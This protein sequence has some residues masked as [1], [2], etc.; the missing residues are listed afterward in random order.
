MKVF[1]TGAT[2]VL[3]RRVVPLLTAAG[4]TVTAVGRTPEKR[5][6]LERAGATAADVY[7][8]DAAA[9]RAAVA[10]HDA[11]VNLATRIPPSSRAAFPGAWKENDRIRR[12]V[13]AHLADAILAAGGGRLVQESFAPMYADGAAAW[14]D[15]SAPLNPAPHTRSTLDAERAAA[16]VTDGGGT[17]VALRFS[18]FYGPDGAFAED[19]IKAVRRGLAP[20]FGAADR[21]F[22]SIH[23]DD[24]ASAVVAALDLPAGVYNVTDDEPLTRRQ[25][26]DALADALGVAP[27]RFLPAWLAR[28]MGSVGEL[29][30]RSQRMSNAKLRAASPWAPRYPSARE[31]WRAA[32]AD[33]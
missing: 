32:V 2:G 14:L 30:T 22:S 19:F 17:G 6:A 5:A 3:G 15:E 12:E 8:F 25:F 9:V 1:V 10:G 23:H 4:H 29:L 16:R 31:G 11:V 20:S 13:S 28:V 33:S 7:L 26:F 27:P 21:Y 24:A 18:F